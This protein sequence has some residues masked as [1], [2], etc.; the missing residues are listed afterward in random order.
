L[1]GNE[2]PLKG[3]QSRSSGGLGNIEEL[4]KIGR[5]GDRDRVSA[6]AHPRLY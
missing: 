3:T 6:L 4:G 5:L 1:R 2:A